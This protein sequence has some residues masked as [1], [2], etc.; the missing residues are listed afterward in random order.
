MLAL[1]AF[2]TVLSM[3]N[4]TSFHMHDQAFVCQL[5]FFHVQWCRVAYCIVLRVQQ[6]QLS[7]LV[8]YNFASRDAVL[9][10][11]KLLCDNKG[12]LHRWVDWL[13]VFNAEL[14]QE[15]Q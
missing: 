9:V 13:N 10:D 11:A 1:C 2:F 12:L 5:F 15:R 3:L 6:R 7:L 8:L 4:N 14:S